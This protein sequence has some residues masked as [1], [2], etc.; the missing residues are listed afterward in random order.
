M[1]LAFLV[2]KLPDLPAVIAGLSHWHCCGSVMRRYLLV[3]EAK[4]LRSHSQ[5]VLS[6]LRTPTT[7]L[8]Q[9]RH[10]CLASQI[11]YSESLLY[12]FEAVLSFA[13]S[14]RHRFASRIA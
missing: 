11:Q 5:A 13:T 12:D 8:T 2:E 10:S 14:Q 3:V 9:R 1:L 7:S 6:P 4:H